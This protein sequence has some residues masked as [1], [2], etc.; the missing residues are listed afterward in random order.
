MQR[1]TVVL[2]QPD[3]PNSAV[4]PLA[5]ASKAVSRVKLPSTL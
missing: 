4:T 2:P 1:I 5:G 3:G